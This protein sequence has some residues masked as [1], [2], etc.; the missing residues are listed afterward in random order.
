MGLL[1]CGLGGAAAEEPGATM[2]TLVAGEDAYLLNADFNLE[3]KPR[4]EE[5]VGRGVP[6]YFVVEFELTRPRW[7]WFDQTLAARTLTYRLSFH[8]LTRQYRLST[9]PLHQS[10]DTLGEAFRVVT[11]VRNWPVA[12]KS[13][14]TPGDTYE[15][16][17]RLYLDLAQLPK[18]LQVTALG[19]RE[20]NVGSDWQRWS[21]VPAP[22]EAK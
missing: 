21:F 19:S 22:A 1:L 13:A 9:G 7:Y 4:L 11:R 16:A 20:W 12:E 8:A 2:P 18:P 6:L 15:A 10:F 14:L 3:L 17:L 5:V